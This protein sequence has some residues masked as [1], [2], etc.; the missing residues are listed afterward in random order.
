MRDYRI[1]ANASR[2]A[3]RRGMTLVETGV[4]LVCVVVL[5]PLCLAAVGGT[6]EANRERMCAHRLGKLGGAVLQYAIE[7]EGQLPGSPGTSGAVLVYNYAGVPQDTSAVP[8]APTQTW[9]WAA[10]LATY[11]DVEL[12]PNRAVRWDQLRQGHFWCPSNDFVS[13][14][15]YNGS[16]GPTGEFGA[17]RMLS[18]NAMRN[19]LIF[20]PSVDIDEPWGPYADWNE[21]PGSTE[22][23]QMYTPNLSAVGSLSEKV[24]LA[25]GS[26]YTNEMGDVD[27]PIGLLANAGGAYADGGPTQNDNWLRSYL[28]WLPEKAKSYRHQHGEIYGINALHFD[29]HVAWFSETVSRHPRWWYPSGTTIPRSEMNSYSFRLVRYELNPSR[30]YEVP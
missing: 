28:R 5:L 24:F 18:Y 7:H 14:P 6:R 17:T 12:D 1:Q 4:M 30:E 29:G 26:R 22:I 8:E 2:R 16:V 23:P 25:D 20:G 10:P 27:H 9:D 11:L 15:Y 3:R 13:L 21:L 19:F